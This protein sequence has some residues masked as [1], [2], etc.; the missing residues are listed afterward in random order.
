VIFFSKIIQKI[1]LLSI[2]ITTLCGTY[3]KN[4]RNILDDITDIVNS[5]KNNPTKRIRNPVNP[6]EILSEKWEENPN[7]YNSFVKWI[8]SL[9]DDLLLLKDESEIEEKLKAMFDEKIVKSLLDALE[10]RSSIDENRNKLF[11]QVVF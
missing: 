9:Y 10:E 8:N 4:T 3:Y 5:V 6:E 1:L 2:I 11:L 7:L